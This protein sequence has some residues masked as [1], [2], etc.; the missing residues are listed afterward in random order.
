MNI[1]YN[2]YLNNKYGKHILKSNAVLIYTPTSGFSSA[3]RIPEL[4][5]KKN[6]LHSSSTIFLTKSRVHTNAL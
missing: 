4:V 3:P 2:I 1:F 6:K 5:R